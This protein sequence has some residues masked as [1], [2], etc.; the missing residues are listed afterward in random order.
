MGRL[1]YGPLLGITSVPSLSSHLNLA[2]TDPPD[3]VLDQL[4]SSVDN[5]PLGMDLPTPLHPLQNRSRSD[6]RTPVF[7]VT[8]GILDPPPGC[9]GS[10]SVGPFSLEGGRGWVEGCQGGA[11]QGRGQGRGRG[12]GAGDGTDLN[13]KTRCGSTLDDLRRHRVH[14]SFPSSSLSHPILP[15]LLPLG[16]PHANLPPD[17]TEEPPVLP[18]LNPHLGIPRHLPPNPPRSSDPIEFG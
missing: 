16:P 6:R 2:S 13:K 10:G 8:A 15:F 9:F 7:P 11:G 17:A 12:R 1:P 4:L 14:R 18:I 3:L 5:I